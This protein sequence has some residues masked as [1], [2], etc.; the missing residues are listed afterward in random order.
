MQVFSS[1]A[2]VCVW[3]FTNFFVVV[4]FPCLLDIGKPQHEVN[5]HRKPNN[6]AKFLTKT[7]IPLE[8]SQNRISENAPSVLPKLKPVNWVDSTKVYFD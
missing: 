4:H 2:H 6:S 7:D 5:E 1:C 3:M 8:G